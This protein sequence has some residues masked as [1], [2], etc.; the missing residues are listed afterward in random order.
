M[1]HNK[2]KKWYNFLYKL[3]Y[4]NNTICFLRSARQ[5]RMILSVSCFFFA[6]QEEQA[7]RTHYPYLNYQRDQD[8][9][10]EESKAKHVTTQLRENAAW[11]AALL[12]DDAFRKSCQCSICH[13]CRA[14]Q[15]VL[16]R[17]KELAFWR[18]V[19]GGGRKLMVWWSKELVLTHEGYHSF[20][21]CA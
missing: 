20:F 12:L 21:S 19:V 16:W 15:N 2:I 1:Y 3:H 9:V 18:L 7:R 14:I 13:Q 17:M 4:I 11:R 8:N 6:K 5:T 10:S